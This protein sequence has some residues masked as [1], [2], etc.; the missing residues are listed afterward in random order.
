MRRVLQKDQPRR[1]Q[2]YGTMQLI[3]WNGFLDKGLLRYEEGKLHI[4]Y[5]RYLESVDGLRREV[6]ALQHDG[7]RARA[8]VFAERWSE[9]SVSAPLL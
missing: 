8:K 3:Q 2:A 5:E 6:L 4:D 9:P 7:D 1:E